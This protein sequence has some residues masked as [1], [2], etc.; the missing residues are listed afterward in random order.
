[1]GT[2]VRTTLTLALAVWAAPASA[3][4]IHSIQFGA[5]LVL[6]RGFDGREEGDVL[7]ENLTG[8]VIEPGLTSAL[9]FPEVEGCFDRFNVLSHPPS[10]VKGFRTGQVF[11][12]WN[13]AFGDRIE[14]G[15]GVA[16]HRKSVLSV[17]RDLFNENGADI[18]QDIKLRVIPF[19]GVVRFMPFGRAGD[20][21]PY[22]G[23]G[24]GLLNWRYSET[25]DFV[26]TSDFTI[27]PERFVADGN[28]PAG[29]LLGGIRVPLGGDIYALTLEGRYQWATGDTGG[30]DAGFVGDK[31]DLGG[32]QFN[33]GFLVRF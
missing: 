6:P 18:V 25:G 28:S 17:Y 23:V 9:A 21:Q 5:G 22:V 29:L 31:I 33:I 32:G 26:D 15:I 10:C 8:F 14:V 20:F 11:G 12:E 13:I 1:M 30:F 27:F 16:F 4:V 3:Q 2:F 7:V 19:T 24:V